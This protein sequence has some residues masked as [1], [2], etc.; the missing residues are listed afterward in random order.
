MWPC[1]GAAMPVVRGRVQPWRQ[2][3]APSRDDSN[4]LSRRMLQTALMWRI[5]AVAMALSK[6]PALSRCSLPYS[7]RQAMV[8]GRSF[9]VHRVAALQ[10][11][12]MTWR[13]SN[14]NRA[15]G[16]TVTGRAGARTSSAGPGLSILKTVEVTRPDRSTALST[17]SE[18]IADPRPLDE[19]SVLPLQE[20]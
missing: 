17:C 7:S 12:T 11:P 1:M 19:S 4:H 15:V 20:V 13:S 18:L 14:L 5:N 10:S 6:S 2:L 3:A 8:K 9:G 16:L